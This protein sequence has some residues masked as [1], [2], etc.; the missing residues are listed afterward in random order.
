M[1]TKSM[2]RGTARKRLAAQG[3]ALLLAT[4][5]LTSNGAASAAP[6]VARHQHGP[7]L[8]TA[9]AIAPDGRIFVVRKE[10]INGNS[11][12]V[13]ET[14]SD[15]GKTWTAARPVHKLPEAVAASGESRPH[16]V[17]G[18]KAELYISWTRTVAFPHIGDIRFVRSLDGGNAFSEPV[19][20]HQDRA[21]VVHSFETPIVD[22]EGRIFVTWVDGRDAAAAKARG[23][24]YAGSAIYYAV[25]SDGGAHFQGDNKLADHS[26]ECCRVGLALNQQ[27]HPAAMWRHVFEPNIRDH[28]SAVLRADGKPAPITRVSFD[29]WKIDACPHHGPSLAFGPD[30]S[31]HQVWFTGNANEGSGARYARQLPGQALEK[32]VQLGSEQAAHPDV[33]VA[34]KTVAVAWKQ[35]DGQATSVLA[36]VSRDNGASWSE[37]SLATTGGDSD[38]PHL[39]ASDKSIVLLW[40]TQNEGTRLLRIAGE[41]K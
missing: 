3:L 34:G 13:L 2:T 10:S 1:R 7:E 18:P 20:V 31:R 11:F 33:A 37:A 41:E 32:P 27:G 25:S 40:R 38:R 6:G 29:N 24:S 36:R 19:T 39:L 9:G 8:G 21:R 14:S 16:I 15:M 23:Q 28:A 30:G 22:K 4:V 12:V 5:S 35:F 26:C 17:F